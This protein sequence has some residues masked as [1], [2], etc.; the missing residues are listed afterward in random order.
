VGVVAGPAQL[1][2]DGECRVCDLPQECQEGGFDVAV[3]T[4]GRIFVLDTI[5][6]TVRIFA[7]VKGRE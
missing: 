4:T 7:R 3:D 1:V 2:R 6:N 5:N